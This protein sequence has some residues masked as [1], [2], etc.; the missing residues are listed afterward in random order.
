MAMRSRIVAIECGTWRCSL[1]GRTAWSEIIGYGRLRE[2]YAPLTGGGKTSLINQ[3]EPV[4]SDAE[5]CVVV[6]ASPTSS[7][8]LI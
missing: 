7:F 8:V 1:I 2:S 6:K 5:R 4:S 3:E